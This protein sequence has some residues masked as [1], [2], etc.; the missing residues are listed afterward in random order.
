M[1]KLSVVSVER[2][3]CKNVNVVYAGFNAIFQSS[4]E[5]ESLEIEIPASMSIDQEY[6]NCELLQ[7]ITLRFRTCSEVRTQNR[8]YAYRVRTADGRTYIIGSSSRPYP[9]TRVTETSSDNVASQES[10]SVEVTLSDVKP[11]PEVRN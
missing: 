4:P 3:P 8:R 7:R 9:I 10:P 11:L 6:K 5:W 1:K 2:T